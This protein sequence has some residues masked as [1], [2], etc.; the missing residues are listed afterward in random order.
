MA[1]KKEYSQNKAECKVTFTLSKDLADNFKRI[2]VLGDFNNWN[3]DM[4]LFSESESDGSYTATIILQANYTYQFRYLGDGVNWF[5]ETD[6]DD[7][8]D[9]YFQGFKNSV[10]NV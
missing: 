4:D 1:I 9:S 8:V 6:A 5:N 10:V 2:S 3:P 7:E